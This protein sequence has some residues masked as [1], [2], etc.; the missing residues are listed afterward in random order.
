MA[1]LSDSSYQKT[2][3]AS[4]ANIAPP[5]FGISPCLEPEVKEKAPVVQETVWKED[6]ASTAAFEKLAIAMAFALT[7]GIKV[8]PVNNKILRD[9]NTSSHLA[10]C[11]EQRDVVDC[12]FKASQENLSKHSVTIS[13]RGSPGIGKSWSSLIFIRKLLKQTENRRPIVFECGQSP[14]QRTTLLIM[15]PSSECSSKA[16]DQNEWAVCELQLLKVP[17]DWLECGIIDIVINPAQHPKDS[18]PSSSLL[19]SASRGHCFIPLCLLM[20]VTLVVHTR[21]Q[22]CAV[23]WSLAHGL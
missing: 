9:D 22:A 18:I 12:A 11:S 13:I 4:I 2:M 14:D 6:K 7:E 15:P 10:I 5:A 3:A 23:S 8:I 21:C 20:I 19:V 17:T 1:S 16:G